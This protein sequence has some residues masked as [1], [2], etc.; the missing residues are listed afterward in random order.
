MIARGGSIFFV[1]FIAIT[2][3]L[4]QDSKYSLDELAWLTGCWSWSQE[5]Y[6]RLEYWM[7]PAG[8][9]MIGMSHTVSDG[10]T[11]EY[12]FLRIV[13]DEDGMIYYEAN[14]S[15]QKQ[16]R[17]KLIQSLAY[18]AVFENPEHDFPQRIIYDL[19]DDGSITARIAGTVKG[20]E[21]YIDF[22]F[23]PV[24]CDSYK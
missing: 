15:G 8:N 6:E 20:E 16:T 21:K 10:K 12:E 17:F 13:D 18:R 7:K 2:S 4:G 24:E 14:P 19:H 5:N 9:M 23:K 11:V 1:L 22:P 3:I